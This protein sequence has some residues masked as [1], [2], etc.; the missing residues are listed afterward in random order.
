MIIQ[1]KAAQGN[2][3]GPSKL[4]V[5]RQPVDVSGIWLTS[6]CND[7]CN[8]AIKDT[9]GFHKVQCYSKYVADSLLDR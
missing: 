7:T 6:A 8:N 9:N 1:D 2:I 4:A 5:A 3:L